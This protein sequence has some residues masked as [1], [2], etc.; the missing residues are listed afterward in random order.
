PTPSPSGRNR[1]RTPRRRR[2]LPGGVRRDLLRRRPRLPHRR[3]R[4]R[5]SRRR[6]RRDGKQP[7]V[8]N[9]HFFLRRVRYA[10]LS[11]KTWT[12]KAAH[13]RLRRSFAVQ[14]LTIPPRKP[15]RDRLRR[16]PPA[17]VSLAPSPFI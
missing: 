5:R 16:S 1:S 2:P 15:H 8:L 10:H 12:K 9:L 3:G 11:S 4:P 13:S 7:L 17:L 6:H 14:P